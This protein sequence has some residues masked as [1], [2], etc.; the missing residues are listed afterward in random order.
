MK[1]FKFLVG[2]AVFC[3][4]RQQVQSS[5]VAPRHRPLETAASTRKLSTKVRQ[6]ASGRSSSRHHASPLVIRGG[7]AAGSGGFQILPISKDRLMSIIIGYYV[8]TGIIGVSDP[9]K[10]AGAMYA[11]YSREGSFA[12]LCYEMI[13]SGTLSIA[14]ALYLAKY[15]RRSVVDIVC[16]SAL[17]GAYVTFRHLLKGTTVKLGCKKGVWDL[18]MAHY[19]LGIFFI[20]ERIGNT[21]TIA[22]IFAC[23]PAIAGFTGML[24]LSYPKAFYGID[25]RDGTERGSVEYSSPTLALRFDAANHL[26]FLS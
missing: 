14:L 6:R 21:E 22:T 20:A 13:G 1:A 4:H 2:I 11:P 25:I 17:P 7:A 8:A 24:S 19:I 5:L 12:H 9:S 16:V 3:S 10:L 26:C 23:L 15:T 18:I